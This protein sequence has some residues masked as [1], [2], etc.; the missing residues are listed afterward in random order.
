[1]YQTRQIMN[2]TLYFSEPKSYNTCNKN[3]Q[4][5]QT[6]WQNCVHQIL[7]FVINIQTMLLSIAD[8]F[9]LNTVGNSF[10]KN[11]RNLFETCTVNSNAYSNHK[12]KLN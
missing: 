5:L 1:M 12:S 4:I 2:Q 7:A 8:F 6:C 3:E 10:C 9:G 11:E